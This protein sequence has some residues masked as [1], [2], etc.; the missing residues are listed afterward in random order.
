VLEQTDG[1]V[2]DTF[3]WDLT[4]LYED[5]KKSI[6]AIDHTQAYEKGKVL[7]N[8]QGVRLGAASFILTAYIANHIYPGVFNFDIE[9]LFNDYMKEYHPGVNASE[10]FQ[11]TYFDLK[12]ADEK[13]EELMN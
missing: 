4:K 2:I 12:F 5:D 9:K 7:I 3:K 11:Y 6:Q 10:W 8:T 1:S 13:Y